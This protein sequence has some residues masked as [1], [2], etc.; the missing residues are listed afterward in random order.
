MIRTNVEAPLRQVNQ[1]AN[2][3]EPQPPKG[4]DKPANRPRARP[5]ASSQGR[6]AT[7]IGRAV[8]GI[9]AMWCLAGC[10]TAATG[11]GMTVAP[12]E[13]TKASGETA[14]AVEVSEVSGGQETNPAWTSQVEDAQFKEALVESLRRAGLLAEANPK[15]GLTARLMKLVQPLAGFDMTV[16]A[17]VRYELKDLQ[18][19]EV[20]WSDTVTTPHTATLGDAFVGIRRLRLANEGAV[21]KNIATLLE[22]LAGAKLGTP[23]ALN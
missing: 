14:S 18:S 20:L 4:G 10:A 15:Y 19:G 23:V 9:V 3:P 8:A 5:A 16:T 2:R 22:R 11:A 7:S 13:I 6:T 12:H 1:S 21:R 17:T